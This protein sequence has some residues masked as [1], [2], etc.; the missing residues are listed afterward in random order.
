MALEQFGKMMLV[1]GN[2]AAL[3][4][5]NLRAVVIDGYDV[6]AYLRE[7]DRGYQSYVT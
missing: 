5:G 1:N 3:E 7:A 4:S 2:F 6:V